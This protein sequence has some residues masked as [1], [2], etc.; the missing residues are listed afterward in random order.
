MKT[1]ELDNTYRL[2][3]KVL[4]SICSVLSII[5]FGLGVLNVFIF[6]YFDG[7]KLLGS[8]E[9]VFSL[10]SLWLLYLAITH[11]YRA[12]QAEAYLYLLSTLVAFAIFISELKSFLF[13]WSLILPMIYFLLLGHRRA[14]LPSLL[15]LITVIMA[16]FNK[17]DQTL[18]PPVTNYFCCYVIVWLVAYAYEKN[19]DNSEQ[20]LQR[21]ALLD[22]LTQ[23]YNRLAMAKRFELITSRPLPNKR[24]RHPAADPM[25]SG[26]CLLLIDIDLFKRVN[27]S[28]GHESGDL[29]LQQ[30]AKRLRNLGSHSLCFRIGGEEFCVLVPGDGIECGIAMAE[31]IKQQISQEPFTLTDLNINITI[32]TGV[33]LYQAPMTLSDL[34]AA[35]DEQLY[36]AKN[37]GRNQVCV[38]SPPPQL[39]PICTV[40]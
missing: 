6:P 31:T 8:L 27:D 22:P 26:V 4:I 3:T 35:A 28:Y 12:W 13:S 21:L 7:A 36:I 16:I 9:F 24:W 32:S 33:A 10:L 29:I 11:Q 20:E 23:C 14:H 17:S 38:A 34:L 39:S 37:N 5:A 18:P 2:R 25:G 15:I 30:F 1:I 19:R 40:A